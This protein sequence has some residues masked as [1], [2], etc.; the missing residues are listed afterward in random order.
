MI[1][2]LVSLISRTIQPVIPKTATPVA[3]QKNPFA[4]E[5]NQNLFLS[6]AAFTGNKNYGKNL[7]IQG[8]YFAGYHNDR[9]N[10]V[11]ARL[12]IEA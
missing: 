12:F 3:R 6:N 5:D 8:G 4:T 1:G 7:P 10:I 2:N 11:G 9:P